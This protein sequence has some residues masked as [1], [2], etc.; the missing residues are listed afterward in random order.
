ME[1]EIIYAAFISRLNV[2]DFIKESIDGK[3]PYKYEF[4]SNRIITDK[5]IVKFVIIPA[6]V[7][8]RKYIMGIRA[9]VAFGFDKKAEDLLTRGKGFEYSG[10]LIDYILEKNK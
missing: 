4:H 7:D 2:E 5:V 8:Q 10:Y 1:K 3:I 9:K 6:G